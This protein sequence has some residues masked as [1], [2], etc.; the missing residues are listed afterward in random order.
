M[1][2][3]EVGSWPGAAS[4]KERVA[5]DVALDGERVED[6]IDRGEHVVLAG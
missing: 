6:A 4:V 2:A 1:T 3:L 5:D